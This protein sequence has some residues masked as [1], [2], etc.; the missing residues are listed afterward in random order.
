MSKLAINYDQFKLRAKAV[1][2]ALMAAGIGLQ[3]YD[4]ILELDVPGLSKLK[5]IG[6]TTAQ[7][8]VVYARAAKMEAEADEGDTSPTEPVDP[9]RVCPSCGTEAQT[10]DE[11]CRN[12]GKKFAVCGGCDS[13]V[14]T[15]DAVPDHCPYCGWSPS[16]PKKKTDDKRVADSKDTKPPAGN[17]EDTKQPP[18]DDGGEST[19]GGEEVPQPQGNDKGRSAPKFMDAIRTLITERGK[20]PHGVV[21]GPVSTIPEGWD[22]D[23]AD[24]PE[25][26]R[27]RIGKPY[28][29]SLGEVFAA[30]I[31]FG[32]LPS[33][34][35]GEREKIKV[36][37]PHFD[38]SK[39][40][41]EGNWRNRKVS[42]RRLWVEEGLP[43]YYDDTGELVENEKARDFWIA[44]GFV[45]KEEGGGDKWR[46]LAREFGLD[47]NDIR[48]DWVEVT[49]SKKE[50]PKRQSAEE[51]VAAL[52]AVPAP[53]VTPG[54]SKRVASVEPPKQAT[55]PGSKYAGELCQ[56][57]GKKPS[58]RSE[59]KGRSKLCDEHYAERQQ[60]IV[61]AEPHKA[62]PPA[63][64]PAPAPSTAEPLVPTVPSASAMAEVPAPTG[65]QRRVPEAPPV[66]APAA[67]VTPAALSAEEIA[68]IA[69]NAA[70]AAVHEITGNQPA[71]TP[72]SPVTPKV[73]VTTLE[74]DTAWLREVAEGRR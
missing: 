3:D 9:R 42:L 7:Q 12:C 2:G 34:G 18:S 37:N 54:G 61:K 35:S 48:P 6:E 28:T 29:L 24:L 11:R 58:Q 25:K 68:K 46:A 16:D 22:V 5:G 36:P 30:R 8:L 53:S 59:G 51:A 65:P 39:P 31:R 72:A 69:V 60:K 41:A 23:E 27:E 52:L 47:I 43:V 21:E 55:A 74:N 33:L 71:T 26:I 13:I 56:A 67:A 14:G 73:G 44:A 45:R 19:E 20:D 49:P 62:A 10:G 40:V 50:R 70:L 63:P 15:M 57:C 4:N 64:A 38:A 66:P 17:G 1:Q 32:K